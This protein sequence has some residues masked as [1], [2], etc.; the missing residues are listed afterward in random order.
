[1]RFEKGCDV[2]DNH[3]TIL[4]VGYYSVL[5]FLVPVWRVCTLNLK[6]L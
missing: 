5:L 1:M 2:V 4:L 6:V 3:E